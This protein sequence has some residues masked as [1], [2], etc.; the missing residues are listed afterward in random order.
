MYAADFSQETYNLTNEINSGFSE[1]RW[2]I[3]GK[4]KINQHTEV[5]HQ[6]IQ[7]LWQ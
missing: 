3:S 7:M 5:D 2:S 4:F 1:V 6:K